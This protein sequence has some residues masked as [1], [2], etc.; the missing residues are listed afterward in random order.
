M[1]FATLPVVLFSAFTV[2]TLGK[3]QQ[4]VVRATLEQRAEAASN[5]LEL[6][7]GAA[8][9]ALD[10]L[11]RSEAALDADLEGLYEHAKR[12]L[13]QHPGVLSITLIGPDGEQIF[14]TLRPFG[15]RLPPTGDLD[16]AKRTIQTGL[17]TISGPFTGSVSDGPVSALG[18]PVLMDGKPRYC[19]RMV[20]RSDVFNDLLQ[21]QKLPP[22]WVASIVNSSGSIVARTKAAEKYIGS[23]VNSKLLA[24]LESGQSNTG[25]ALTQDGQRAVFALARLPYWDWAV[26]MGV[27]ESDL[28]S[29]LR[30]SLLALAVGGGVLLL[31]GMAAAL[32]LSRLL[33]AQIIMASRA[34]AALACG[35]EP[36]LPPTN[37]RELDELGAALGT[38]KE[39][40]AQASLDPLT[41]LPNRARFLGMASAMQVRATSQAQDMAVLFIDLDGFKQVNDRFGHDRGDEILARVATILVGSLREGDVVGRLGGDEFAVCMTAPA[42][43][44]ESVTASVADR[45]VRSISAIGD[46][47]GCSIGIAV[48]T[49]DNADLACGIKCAD[50]AMYEANRRGKNRFVTHGAARDDTAA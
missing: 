21:R 38:A 13:P 32:W 2:Y 20:T 29:P 48:F 18:V 5:A 34:S 7:L 44:I 10:A 33:A 22:E 24:A 12:L 23:T 1:V 3:A 19:L 27:P 37:I 45:I 15:D 26:I 41:G 4:V 8:A 46:G 25:H 50:E 11:A 9:A 17:P 47:I 40:E 16:A 30:D 39:R 28:H 31:A 35:D 42:T 49:R 14:N 6:R 43:T 36:V